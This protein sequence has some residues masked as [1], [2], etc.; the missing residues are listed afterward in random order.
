M[1]DQQYKTALKFNEEVAQ[2]VEWNVF[3]SF[4]LDGT[5]GAVVKRLTSTAV[6]GMI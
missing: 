5:I 3:S 1:S 6:A 2:K 4:I